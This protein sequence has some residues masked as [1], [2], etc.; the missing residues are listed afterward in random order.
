MG[1]KP[2][3]LFVGLSL[4]MFG[5]LEKYSRDLIKGLQTLGCSV[6]AWG[7]WDAGIESVDG[8]EI[9]SL[10]PSHPVMRHSLMQRVYHRLWERLLQR[11]LSRH[12]ASYDLMI[13]GHVQVLPAITDVL[14]HERS[15][16]WVCT[17]GTDVWGEWSPKVRAAL[18]GCDHILTIS[19][20]TRNSIVRRLPSAPVSMLAPVV[21]VD[22]FVPGPNRHRAETCVRLLTVSSLRKGQQKGHDTVIRCLPELNRRLAKPIQY[23]IVGTGPDRARLER[24]AEELGIRGQLLF[25]GFLPEHELVEAYQACEVFVMPS[26]VIQQPDGRWRGDGFGIVYAEASACAKPIVASNQGGVT[27]AVLDGVTGF[28]VDPNS[29]EAVTDAIC[30]ILSDPALATRIGQAGREY[31]VRNFSR[32]VFEKR[33]GAILGDSSLLHSVRNASSQGED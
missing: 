24:L 30:R 7:V 25:S 33:L 32:P 8:I 26:R 17:Y 5:G 19:K 21:D 2:R 12:A 9:C 22:T 1:A 3:I 13:A 14:G 20:Y 28:C 11:K 31:V 15:Q 10:A 27:D 29:L 4:G 16:C 23:Q 6:D 18:L